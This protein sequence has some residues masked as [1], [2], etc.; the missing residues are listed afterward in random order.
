MNYCRSS[1]CQTCVVLA[2][3]NAPCTRPLGAAQL[4]PLTHLW[5]P[6]QAITFRMLPSPSHRSERP[7]LPRFPAF[8]RV[9]VCWGS[10]TGDLAPARHR[11][12]PWRAEGA[13]WFSRRS[14]AA[15]DMANGRMGECLRRTAQLK[16]SSPWPRSWLFRG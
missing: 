13:R 8:H 11:W 3:Q 15:H 6:Q 9:T 5:L 2:L 14:Q 16:H 1:A 4:A 12:A 10:A 7:L